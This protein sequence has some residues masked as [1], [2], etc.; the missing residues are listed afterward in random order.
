MQAVRQAAY[1]LFL[2]ASGRPHQA[3]IAVRI[4]QLAQH[5]RERPGVSQDPGQLRARQLGHH[6]RHD[7]RRGCALRSARASSVPTPCTARPRAAGSTWGPAAAA[8]PACASRHCLCGY[9]MCSMPRRQGPAPAR[10]H[11]PSAA[12]CRQE[13]SISRGRAAADTAAHPAPSASSHVWGRQPGRACRRGRPSQS[14]RGRATLCG[15]A[16]SACSHRVSMSW[17]PVSSRRP[18][19]PR[20]WYHTGARC[21]N[22]LRARLATSSPRPFLV[23][24]SSQ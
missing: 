1:C 19:L 9:S 10:P 3:V 6:P 20:T 15:G 13:P 5:V 17:P 16:R 14:R 18:A 2:A 11:Y 24:W 23:G 12:C 4:A 22:L 8:R 7:A 21:V